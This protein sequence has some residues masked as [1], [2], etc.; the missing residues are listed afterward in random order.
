MLSRPKGC[1]MTAPRSNC[2]GRGTS[3]T[4][5][6]CESSRARENEEGIVQGKRRGMKGGG[7]GFART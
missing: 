4:Y 6:R 3:D 5:Q 2:R 7:L 1:F